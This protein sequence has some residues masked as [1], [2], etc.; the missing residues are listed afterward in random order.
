MTPPSIANAL[1]FTKAIYKIEESTFATVQAV[2]NVR[3]PRFATTFF[4]GIT[5]ARMAMTDEANSGVPITVSSKLDDEGAQEQGLP[6]SPQALG[7]EPQ[8]SRR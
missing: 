8:M 2:G 3:L 1:S 4:G 6:P 7:G 5:T